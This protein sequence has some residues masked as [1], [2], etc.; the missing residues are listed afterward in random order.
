MKRII[1]ITGKTGAGK[2]V[3]ELNLRHMLGILNSRQAFPNVSGYAFLGP[4]VMSKKPRNKKIIHGPECSWRKT[5][6]SLI[7]GMNQFHAHT[8][9]I[10][11]NI[12]PFNK[13]EL[14]FLKTQNEI[15]LTVIEQHI[16]DKVCLRRLN[17]R[18]ER[19]N[20]RTK[21]SSEK[22]L[23]LASISVKAKQLQTECPNVFR[24]LS[25]SGRTRWR[26]RELCREL[27]IPNESFEKYSY[28]RNIQEYL[29]QRSPECL[30]KIFDYEY[31]RKLKNWHCLRGQHFNE[32][33][34][35]RLK[36]CFTV[37][38]VIFEALV[39]DYVKF[40]LN[41]KEFELK[42]RSEKCFQKPSTDP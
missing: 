39:A 42:K 27:S 8:L 37:Q 10:N 25:A 4:V 1:I 20:T 12:M 14:D 11:A 3:M 9:I 41:K 33:Q 34:N 32:K 19:E 35:K 29:Q 15:T 24:F 5:L 7:D 36:Y 23:K 2:S 38:L 40:R 13:S 6:Q 17:Q 22:L 31:V 16:S 26:F 18:R 28:H 30:T 21:S